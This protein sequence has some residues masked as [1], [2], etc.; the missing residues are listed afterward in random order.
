[1][2][3]ENVTTRNKVWNAFPQST[4]FSDFPTERDWIYDQKITYLSSKVMGL[5]RPLDQTFVQKSMPIKEET[6]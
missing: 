2:C 6:T 5:A 3:Y 4:V 1:M